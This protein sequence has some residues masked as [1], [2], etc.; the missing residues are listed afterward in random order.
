M[1][2]H[3]WVIIWPVRVSDQKISQ[4]HLC[5][6]GN[7][8]SYLFRWCQGPPF[9]T[10]QHS[11]S[12]VLERSWCLSR[13]LPVA[14]GGWWKVASTGINRKDMMLSISVFQGSYKNQNTLLCCCSC[15]TYLDLSLTS[16]SQY[17]KMSYSRLWWREGSIFVVTYGFQ[18]SLTCK[19]HHTYYK[20]RSYIYKIQYL[21]HHF[22]DC[23]DTF[24]RLCSS[25]GWFSYQLLW[26]CSEPG[27]A[28]QYRWILS[29]IFRAALQS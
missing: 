17:F 16:N 14:A 10:V 6:P 22:V 8:L 25:G 13:L 24:P 1:D 23:K 27:D 26:A 21:I 19:T 15:L 18:S 3:L 28:W 7:L 20:F 4:L 11:C 5:W 12:S 9:K 2:N 29:L